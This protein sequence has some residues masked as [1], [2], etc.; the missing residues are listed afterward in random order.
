MDGEQPRKQLTPWSNDAVCDSPGEAIYLQDTDT[1]SLWSPTPMPIR[2]DEPYI[3]R[4][5]F[6]YTV[7]EHNSHGL[8][9]ELTQFV[10]TDASVKIGL[11]R[12]H[13]ETTRQRN[14]A[15]TYYVQPVLG[16]NVQD[17]ALHL[18]SSITD[19]GAMLLE[20]RYD[21]NWA[22]KVCYVHTS[23]EVTSFTGDRANFFGYGD[24]AAPDALKYSALSGHID[25]AL[26]PCAAIRGTLTLAPGEKRE[27]VFLLGAA[28]GALAA[29]TMIGH[30]GTLDGA[31]NGLTEAIHFWK[32]KVSTVQVNV[33]SIAMSRM[34]NGWLQYQVIS[35]RLWARTGFYQSGGAFGFRDQLQ[36]SLAV[37][38]L[39][40]EVTRSQILLH[41]RHQFLEGDILHWWH[42][43]L[44]KG[45][46]THVSDDYL[47]LPYAT[48]EYVRI[49][50]DLAILDEII[51]FLETPILEA[52]EN[53][54]YCTPSV[55]DTTATLFEHCLQA[56]EKAL[57]FGIHGLPLMGSGDW[58]DSMNTVGNR[59]LGESV[60][61]GWFLAD[62][63]GKLAPLCRSRQDAAR[64]DRYEHIRSDLAANIEQSAWDRQLVQACL[65]RQWSTSGF[66]SKTAECRIDSIAQSWAVISARG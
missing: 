59:G 10:P 14:M 55:S 28:K 61:L 62:I 27:I 60:W 32:I 13:N 21:Q 50:G 57:C 65:F 39:W 46:R 52:F 26:D 37:A 63:L 54:R 49:T 4:H 2:E 18:T 36:D 35:C 25:V 17:T 20:N 22:G 12:V 23:M 48:A 11:L 47:W 15:I 41:A 66:V 56:V 51:P 3:I 19:S 30:Y 43:P 7:F 8:S 6:G 42:E 16:I 58:N 9:Q 45:T 5:G 38:A 40:P 33:P 44:G 34:L 24:M 29:E 31:W 53:E 1:G 64:A